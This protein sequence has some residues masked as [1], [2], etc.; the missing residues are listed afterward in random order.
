ME[1]KK[2]QLQYQLKHTSEIVL[3]DA[4]STPSGLESW[5]ADKVIT[6]NSHVVTFKWATEERTARIVACRSYSYIRF[7]WADSEF[8]REYFEIKMTYDELTTDFALE[9]TDFA[10]EAEAEDLEQLW[11]S[12][13]ETLCRNC[14]F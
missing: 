12:Q 6:D 2:I 5:F 10:D 14:G 11:D 13:V 3:W 9:I 8:S 1:R 4:I 7:K